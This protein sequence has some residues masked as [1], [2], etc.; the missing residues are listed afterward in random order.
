MTASC[1]GCDELTLPLDGQTF[2]PSVQLVKKNLSD[3]ENSKFKWKLALMLSGSN[4]NFSASSL[5]R[6]SKN[7]FFFEKLKTFK[8][9]HFFSGNFSLK[10]VLQSLNGTRWSTWHFK[11]GFCTQ[12]FRLKWCLLRMEL[13]HVGFKQAVAETDNHGPV[14][15]PQH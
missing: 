15:R 6:N 11:N 14:G 13:I 4:F 5:A 7:G 2:C 8:T 1:L 9:K 12:K 10:F 3:F